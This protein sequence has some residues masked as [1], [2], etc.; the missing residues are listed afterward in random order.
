MT[1]FLLP[2]A[3]LPPPRDLPADLDLVPVTLLVP[4]Y[5]ETADVFTRAGAWLPTLDYPGEL[6]TVLWLVDD[7]RPADLA[8]ARAA[9]AI[10]SPG[11]AGR[12]EVRPVP[13]LTPKAVAINHVVPGIPDEIVGI[14][15]ADSV[16]A[17]DQVRRAVC[18]LTVDG[19]D[20]VDCL[21]F[22]GIAPGAVNQ[23]TLAS[24]SSFFAGM[25]FANQVFGV[26][27]L[28]GSSVYFRRDAFTRVGNLPE[29]GVEEFYDWSLRA[30]ENGLRIGQVRSYTYG[31]PT[32]RVRGAVAQRTRWLRGQ[33]EIGLRTLGT[34]RRG[35]GRRT[36]ALFTASILA[37][38]LAGPL[39]AAAVVSKRAR[40]VAAG[41]L[42]VE[43][44]RIRRLAQMPQWRGVVSPYGWFLLLPFE[45]VES[46]SAWRG[47]VELIRGIDTWHSV[48]A[49]L[50]EADDR[51]R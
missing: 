11:F 20:A 36:A 33:L 19:H 16:P 4:F 31:L 7:R 17:A 9:A 10:A 23:A 14:Y 41:M 22:S 38:M 5:R 40:P 26:H 25:T 37:Q 43:L 30:A 34:A 48:R 29:Q 42:V 51:L 46:V 18:A 2:V 39:L 8:I 13:S 6:L 35:P 49:R 12:L 24:A 21:E 44:M 45:L 1:G 47:T 15:D 27:M 32:G 50:G 28:L 3:Q